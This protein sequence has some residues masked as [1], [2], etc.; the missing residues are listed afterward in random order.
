MDTN[1]FGEEVKDYEDIVR[2]ELL[3]YDKTSFEDRLARL[4]YV[5]TIFPHGQREFASDESVAIFHETIT[6]FINC[7]FIATIVL[8]Q[9]FIERRFQ[10]YFS[11]RL[12]QDERAK[13]TLYKLLEGFR[14]DGFIDEFLIDKIDTLRLKRNPFVHHRDINDK[15]AFRNRANAAKV[16]VNELLEQDAKDALTVMFGIAKFRAF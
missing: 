5:N 16:N 8:A 15:N 9:S 4:R 2:D 6:C 3:T 7:Q 11:M 14:N 1:L 12:N 10:E 13:Q